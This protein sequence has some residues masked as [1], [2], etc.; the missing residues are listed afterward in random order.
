MPGFLGGSTSSGGT[1]GEIRF[2]AELIDPVT[3]LR[4]SEPQTLID[5]DF[6]YG[7][8]P[9]KWETVELINNTP[10]FFS[11]SGD[12]TIPNLVDIIT[13]AGS[14]EVKITTSLAHGLAVGIPI[15]VS[16]TKSL[17]AD[18]AYI[19]NS[20]PDST[21]FTYLCKQ[22]QLTTASIVDLYT[23][24]I[25][26]QFFQG[27]QIKISESEGIITDAQGQSKLTIKTDSPHGFGVAT[28]FYFLNLNSTISQEFDSS[29]TSAKTFDSS[30]TATAQSFD[31]SNTLTT[32][33][34]DLSNKAY[35]GTGADSTIASVN[36]SDDTFTV[37]HQAAENFSGLAIGTPLY[38]NISASS[39]Y[40]ATAPRG[41][42][43]LKTNNNLGSS[44]S[45]F[46]VSATPGGTA[47][48]LTVSVTGFFRRANLASRFA[49][50]NTDNQGQTTLTLTASNPLTFDGANNQGSIS[51]VNST[52][53]GS[54]IIQMQN[55][56][57][58]TVATGLYV[59]AMV[60]VSSTGT[61]PGGLTNN[62][63]YWVSYF[64][65]VVDPAPGLVQI[66]LAATP[67]GSDIVL[68]NG[69]YSGTF[70]VQKIGVSLDK[71]IIHIQNHG[72]VT[73][74]LVKY[75][76][77]TGGAITRSG[78]TKDFHYV[79]RLDASNIQLEVSP[80]LQV[81][82]AV[83][84]TTINVS[85]ESYKVLAFTSTGNNSF[86][87]SG[88]GVM[89]FLVVG[90]GGGGGFDMGGGGG[91]GGMVEGTFTAQGGTY[92]VTVGAGGRGVGANRDGNGGGHQ[93]GVGSDNGVDSVLTGPGNLNVRAKGGGRGGSSYFDYS[94]GAGGAAGGS[95]GGTSGYS[96]GS[97]RAGGSATQASQG[98]ATG[99]LSATQYGNR[100]GQGGGQYYSGGGGG[101]GANG[102][103]STNQPNGGA[104]RQNAILGTNYFWAGGG[105][106]SGYSSSGG[107]G[108]AGGGGGGAVNGPWPG[109]SGLNSG[110]QGGGGGTNTWANTPGGNGGANT[111]GGGG[112]GA[113]YNNNNKGGDG[114]S[115]IVV[116]RWKG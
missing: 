101:A 65:V 107:S 27:S 76:Y 115:G 79:T 7:L 60:F 16:G 89:E 93:Y 32:Y 29:N 19:I 55:Q 10:S 2:P 88:T 84:P 42:V 91:A 37:T 44:S 77:P 108:G 72:L 112:G 98:S 100:G 87:V 61:V 74:D 113:H 102:A 40:F 64:Q 83:T 48:D 92:N 105:G 68:S 110:Q 111:G 67:G 24:I 51:T 75:T 82:S 46:Q 23:S 73:G 109:G 3:K 103:D 52:S 34:L 49:G 63:T 95:G 90:G 38:Y 22:N 15:N 54:T 14:R 21:T 50:N 20:I 35:S 17:T 62:T 70:T 45:V 116:V 97:T 4:V 69:S 86:T 81:T 56:A 59:G 85:G 99:T 33:A 11:A 31:G 28:P 78:F 106:G 36:T 5:T 41:I 39:G 25:T 94:P 53:T 47:I 66:K 71:D 26:G 96:N 30:N 80:G 8:Q 1:S 43:F 57:G 58:S 18:G 6:E 13:T 104:G 9:T 12:T 114:G